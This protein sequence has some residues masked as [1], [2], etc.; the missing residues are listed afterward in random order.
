MADINPLEDA[1]NNIEKNSRVFESN[2]NLGTVK[3]PEERAK[4]EMYKRGDAA[5]EQSGYSPRKMIQLT[6][7]IKYTNLLVTDFP[8]KGKFYPVDLKVQIRGAEVEEIEHFSTMSDV[9]PID[10]VYHLNDILKS[11]GKA[12]SQSNPNFN[13]LDLIDGD[14]IFVIL[15]IKDLTFTEGENV[16]P[17]KIECNKGHMNLRTLSNNILDSSSESDPTLEKYYSETE[18]CYVIKTKSYGEFRMKPPRVCLTEYIYKRGRKTLGDKKYWDKSYFSV[19]PFIDNKLSGEIKDY[20]VDLL[21]SEY[22]RWDKKQFAIIYKLATQI[23]IGVKPVIKIICDQC[24][25]A[26]EGPFRIPDG[27]KSLFVISD[28]TDE[29]I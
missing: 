4:E 24:Q 25:E 28:I 19:L 18:R 20:D 16:L 1:V 10:E 2:G 7:P 12:I 26:A 23:K 27:T 15:A 13:I 5:I 8:S 22:S 9:D 21:Y 3:L 17:I 11:C 14:R 6:T 29:L